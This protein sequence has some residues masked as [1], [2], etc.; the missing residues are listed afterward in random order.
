[1]RVFP[2]LDVQFGSYKTPS[3]LIAFH[4]GDGKTSDVLAS[5]GLRNRDFLLHV[6][7]LHGLQFV[8]TSLLVQVLIQRLE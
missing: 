4:V 2:L 7:L 6:V 8:V 1:M 5:L 3:D